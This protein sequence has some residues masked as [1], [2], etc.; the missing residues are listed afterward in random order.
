[1]A[2]TKYELSTEDIAAIN[3]VRSLLADRFDDLPDSEG[4]VPVG[5]SLVDRHPLF[6]P[7]AVV[8]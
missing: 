7:M 4:W 1:M 5:I 6:P 2:N 8:R 3:S